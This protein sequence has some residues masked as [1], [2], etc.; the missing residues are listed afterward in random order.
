M[1]RFTQHDNCSTAFLLDEI[2]GASSGMRPK[3]CFVLSTLCTSIAKGECMVS[4]YMLGAAVA[5]LLAACG[6]QSAGQAVAPTAALQATTAAEEQAAATAPTPQGDV[7]TTAAPVTTSPA[8]ADSTAPVVASLDTLTIGV[9]LVTNALDR[10]VYATHAGDGSGRLFVV[11]KAGV[12]RV[13]RDSQPEQEAFLDIRDRVGAQG[14]E[15][16]LLSVAF[17]PQF[18][19]NGR[20][21]VNYTDR[22]GDTVI[23]RFDSDKQRANAASETILLQIDQPYPN[24]NGG[25][26]QFGPDGLLYIGM[27]DGGSAGDPQNNGQ[28]PQS[29]LG[30]MLRLDVDNGEPYAIPPGNLATS[31]RGAEVWATGLRN[32]WRF[33]FDRE[34]GD[35][36]IGDVG[37]NAIEEVNFQPVGK[38]AG[39]NYGWNITEGSECYQ[40]NCDP[41]QF[42]LPVGEYSHDVGCSVTGGYVYRGAAF[43]VLRGVY[44]FGDY[45]SGRIWG[46][47]QQNGAWAQRELGQS[48]LSISSFGEDEAGEVYITNLA[49]NGLYRVLAK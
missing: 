38:G 24:H 11:E 20:L 18:A 5:L 3:P 26:L 1:F 23:A 22:R 2:E 32:P 43:P 6:Q 49:D 16:G 30:K 44:L 28:T 27:G 8:S 39:A 14:S 15:Q 9:E 37:Q 12:V 7:T 19:E 21:F 34:T 45:C 25:Q 35:L 42:V 4:R 41:A 33:S 40:G 29:L 10:P 47:Q 17:H 13:L 36:F 31:G 46:L 48:G